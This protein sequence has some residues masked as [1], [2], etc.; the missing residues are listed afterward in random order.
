MFNHLLFNHG[1]ATLAMCEAAGLTGDPYVRE[2]AQK[3]VEHILK[4]QTPDGGWNFLSKKEGDSEVPLS[5]WNV[6]ALCAAKEAGLT[7]PEDAMR[8]AL[9]FYRKSTLTERTGVRVS[10]SIKNDDKL[11]R[12][13]LTA[14]ALCVRQLLGEDPR[15]ADMQAIIAKLQDNM[16]ASK[17]EW[18]VGWVPNATRI[19]DDGRA[20]FDPYYNYFAT[21]GMFCRGGKDW[22]AWNNALVKALPEMQDADGCWRLN[23][24]FTRQAGF[25]YST[26]LSIMALQSYY[27]IE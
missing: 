24:V 6:Q 20:K 22:E 18:G 5:S 16:P 8:R 2:S 7:V 26:A 25:V 19:D 21:Q 11:D 4:T 14:V 10:W 27:R 12:P 15:A 1:L 17:K 13:S 23:D 9:E 3:G